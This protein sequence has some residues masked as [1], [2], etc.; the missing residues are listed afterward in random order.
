MHP[1]QNKNSSL[2][3]DKQ[4][5]RCWVW[6][7]T[8]CCFWSYPL[9][10]EA[11][12]F[13]VAVAVTG[14]MPPHRRSTRAIKAAQHRADA[15][16]FTPIWKGVTQACLQNSMP[17]TIINNLRTTTM[18]S[19]FEVVFQTMRWAWYRRLLSLAMWTLECIFAFWEQ[20][21]QSPRLCEANQPQWWN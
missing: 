7:P 16:Q 2:T 8:V 19:W 12:E 18:E 10:D 13:G 5:A 1:N 17:P 15:L 14:Q 3:F 20:V 6:V 11:T 21:Q 9:E 4:Q